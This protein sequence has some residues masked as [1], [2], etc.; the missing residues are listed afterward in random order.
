M[1]STINKLARLFASVAAP[2]AITVVCYVFLR[3]NATTVAMLYLLAVLLIAAFSGLL[4]STIAA[5]TAVVCLNFFFL[6]PVLTFTIADPQN[7]LALFAF[8][9]TAIVGS[10]LS[11]Y[12]RKQTTEAWN[13][14]HETEQLYSLSRTILLLDE[15][16][17]AASQ[18]AGHI[19]R[20]F[21][22]KSAVIFERYSASLHGGDEVSAHLANQLKEVANKGTLIKDEERELTIASIRLGVEPI[23]SLA[24]EGS[25][26]SDGAQQ[27]LLNLIAIALERE[28]HREQTTQAQAER[29][30]ERLKS[31]LLDAIAHEFKTPLTS[32]KAASGSILSSSL[33]R[34][35]E[36]GDLTAAR[37]LITVIEEETDRLTDLVNDAIQMARIE[38]GALNPKKRPCKIGDLV[39]QVAQ[40]LERR[41]DGRSIDLQLSD[42]LPTFAADPDLLSLTLRLLLDNAFKYS[43]PL[44]SITVGA[45]QQNGKIVIRV[46]DEGAGIPKAEQARIFEKFYRGPASENQ[47]P[48]AGM[49]LAIAR[50]IALA[51]GGEIWI[52]SE[53]GEGTTFVLTI[54]AEDAPREDASAAD[55][56]S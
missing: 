55:I 32:I 35:R 31:T 49:G 2:I 54:P 53:S 4:E 27:A 19:V 50:E 9:A 40:D 25:F 8:L 3:V 11:S 37:E 39:L 36:G 44:S 24:T 42:N 17:S 14:K 38:A 30:S 29:K 13:S 23:G 12:A 1:R 10:Q 47:V 41:R 52:E 28:R 20:I 33:L 48:G 45:V 5:V 6:P 7:W 15:H 51:H 21:G 18:I 46:H 43:P 34:T 22:F 56:G 16:S 26:L